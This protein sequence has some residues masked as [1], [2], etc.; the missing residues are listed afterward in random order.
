LMP[1][2]SIGGGFYKF[3]LSTV[4][5]S[6]WVLRF[7]HLP[8]HWYILK[9]HPAYYLPR[10][11]ISI[12]LLALGASHL[13][14]LP[15]KYLIMFPFL[16][17][18]PIPYPIQFPPSFCPLLSSPSSSVTGP[19]WDWSQGEAPRPDIIADAMVC[20]YRQDP[21]M[22]AFQEAQQVADWDK[23]RYLHS[24]NGLK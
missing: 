17:M 3:P 20:T 24:T 12:H 23:S 13:I 1:C 6:L 14:P 11:Y 2:L 16:L 10:V 15:L 4:G 22:A 5:P 7:S 19:N 8:G 9:G 21:S 18:F